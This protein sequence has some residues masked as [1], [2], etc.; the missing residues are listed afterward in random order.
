MIAVIMIYLPGTAYFWRSLP[1]KALCD[2]W[3]VGRG[4][5]AC[6]QKRSRGRRFLLSLLWVSQ[7]LCDEVSSATVRRNYYWKLKFKSLNIFC[8]I[9]FKQQAFTVCRSWCFRLYFFI[10][11]RRIN[12]FAQVNGVLFYFMFSYFDLPE[13]HSLVPRVVFPLHP[14]DSNLL[15]GVLPLSEDDWSVSTVA[16]LVQSYVPIHPWN[17]PPKSTS[18]HYPLYCL[19]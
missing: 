2:P 13:V 11:W 16:Q 18:D 9:S 4:S 1:E 17:S 8:F 19:K 7:R 6:I 10:L 15:T 14:L 3:W 5:P 12:I